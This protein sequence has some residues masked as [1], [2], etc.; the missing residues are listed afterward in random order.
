MGFDMTT[1]NNLLS[2]EQNANY[3]DWAQLSEL[4]H[5]AMQDAAVIREKLVSFLID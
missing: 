4:S 1:V 2:T 3:T 5:H